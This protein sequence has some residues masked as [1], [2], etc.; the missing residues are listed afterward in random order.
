VL[1]EGPEQRAMIFSQGRSKASI[2]ANM[3]LHTLQPIPLG[4]PVLLAALQ[5]IHRTAYSQPSSVQN[6]SVD[7]CGGDIAVS[8]KLLNRSDIVAILQ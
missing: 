6:V 3:T 2:A 7:H 1:V 8:Q 4:P 5:P